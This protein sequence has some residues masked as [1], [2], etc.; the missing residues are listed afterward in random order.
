MDTPLRT[1]LLAVLA[2]DAAGYSRLM[3]LDDR[4]TVAALDTARAVFSAEIAAHAGRVVD[5]AGDSILAVFET[6]TAAVQAARAIQDR[7]GA[8][9]APEE[10]KLHFRLGVHVGDVIEKADGT[11]YGDGVNVAARLQALA[12]PGGVTVS[13]AV[14]GIVAG[15]VELAFIDIGEQSVKNIARPVRVYRL[16]RG[17]ADEA[18]AAGR[19]AHPGTA[20]ALRF[21]AV[22]IRLAQRQVWVDGRE[23]PIGARAFDVLSLLVEQRRRVVPRKELLEQV[24]QALPAGEASLEAQVAALRKQ[25]GRKAIATVPGRGYQFTLPE[26]EAAADPVTTPPTARS[27]T[28]TPALPPPPASVLGRDVDFAALER[29][30][31]QHRLVTLVGAGGIGKTTLALAAAH[32]L[33]PQEPDGAAWV[34]LAPLADPALL[35]STVARGLGIAAAGANPLAALVKALS[36]RRML[37]VLDNAEHLLDAVAALVQAVLA[38]A[39]GVHVLVTSQ[40]ALNVGGERLFRLGALA[41]PELGTPVEEALGYGAVA[42]FVD[43]AQAADRHFRLTE[44]KLPAVIDLCTRLDGVALAIKLA[45]ARLPLFGLQGLQARLSERFRLL[46][47]GPRSAPSRQQTLRAALDWSHG[48]LTPHEQIVFRR[49]GVFA[50]GFPLDLAAKTACDETHDEWAV[51]EALGGLVDRS[52]VMLEAGDDGRY[53]LLESARDY[54][55]GKLADAGELPATHERAARVLRQHFPE[56]AEAEPQTLA[57]HLEQ[58]ACLLEAAQEWE[59]AAQQA[60]ARS[61]HVEAVLHF[62]NAI[63]LTRTLAAAAADPG[64]LQRK[65]L[66]LQL[67]LGPLVMMTQG[68]GSGASERLYEDALALSRRVGTASETF[69]ATFNLWFVA[70]SQLQFDRAAQLIEAS[71]DLARETGDERFVLQAH[72][73]GYTTASVT[74]DW[75]QGLQDTEEVYRRY[76]PVDGPF[77]RSTFAGHD[78]GLCSIGARATLLV[79]LGRPEEAFAQLDLLQPLIRECPHPPSQ[80]IGW[81][82]TCLACVMAREPRRMKPI[83]D[84]ALAISRRMSLQQYDGLFAVFAAWVSALIDRDPG[85]LAALVAGIDKF[86]STGTRLRVSLLRAIA[87]EACGAAG[88]VEAGQ[89]FAERALR[90]LLERK[91]L[92]WHAYTLI[93]RGDLQAMAAR[94][95]AAEASFAEALAVAQAQQALG[96]ELRAANGLARLW[97]QRGRAAEAR[98][99]VEPLLARFGSGLRTLDLDQARALLAGLA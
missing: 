18:A 88:L 93:V 94:P 33:Q 68:L 36:Q 10:R 59:R 62:E 47:H 60:L 20:A 1:R 75:A 95:E 50:A 79:I 26:G 41:A 87:A 7:L 71:A 57:R 24:W 72:H 63:R 11:V 51:I 34:D 90:E 43:Q 32:A 27:A 9:E 96:L 53:R 65:A 81:Y 92:G 70:E 82:T 98:L 97:L 39:P 23:A 37:L 2:A 16:A 40:A 64:D 52:L 31:Q 91:E 4:G 80:I 15:R 89:A 99:L 3:S 56:R 8:G 61:G 45:A 49:L 29:L 67:R 76:R 77:H 21:G 28:D 54:A 48:L 83:A 55:L 35:V 22:E 17:V 74:G 14:Q 25:L 73:A 42:L 58:G 85:V 78:P 5:M 19:H 66:A 38:G 86:E 6:A 13:Q 44:D 46:G 30:L 69:I 12:D 84:E